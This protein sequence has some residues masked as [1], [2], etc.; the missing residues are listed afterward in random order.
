M[1]SRKVDLFERKKE[2]T[3][4]TSSKLTIYS[5]SGH[6][7]QKIA[8]G[9]SSIVIS[10]SAMLESIVAINS[11]GKVVPFYYVPGLATSVALNDRTTGEKLNVRVTKGETIIEGKIVSLDSNNVIILVKDELVAISKYDMVVV[12]GSSD[13]SRPSLTFNDI[14]SSITLTYL[15]HNIS[16]N[17]S[18]TALL[19]EVNSILYLRLSGNIINDTEDDITACTTLVSGEVYQ[20]RQEERT[21]NE[22][23]ISS[24]MRK[25]APMQSEQVPTSRLQDFIKYDVGSRIIRN[26]DIAELGINAYPITKVYSHDTDRRQFTS[27]GY[28]FIAKD[29][30]P[31]CFVNTYSITGD[32]KD[33]TNSGIGSFIGANNIKESQKDDKIYFMLGDTTVVSCFTTVETTRIKSN[34]QRGNEY[35]LSDELTS[36]SLVTGDKWIFVTEGIKTIINNRNAVPIK[37][38]IKHPIYDRYLVFGGNCGGVQVNRKDNYLIWE[39]SIPAKTQADFECKVVTVEAESSTSF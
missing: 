15:L 16:W 5:Q 6:M 31:A 27:F 39:L 38:F 36:S 28:I 21:Y 3:S 4:N 25:S 37:L 14:S 10:K 18:G 9:T 11:L 7:V 26:K 2:I 17:C 29:F 23:K 33:S 20:N 19:D 12:P 22:M 24:S 32:I 35:K 13:S 1:S 8:S 34:S 30:V